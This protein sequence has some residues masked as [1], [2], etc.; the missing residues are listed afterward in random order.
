MRGSEM[1]V[2]NFDTYKKE[3]MKKQ[4]GRAKAD[5]AMMKLLNDVLGQLNK[6]NSK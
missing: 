6:P 1:K 2:V 5:Q 3:K 4:E